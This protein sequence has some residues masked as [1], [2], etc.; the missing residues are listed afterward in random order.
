MTKKAYQT[1]IEELYRQFDTQING[2]NDESVKE[3]QETYGLNELT[4]S[5]GLSAGEILW[6]NVNNIIVYLLA[7]AIIISIFMG[8]YIEAIAVFVALLIAV[9]TGFFVELKA[10]SSVDALKNMIFT[11]MK[12]YR[13]GSLQEISSSEIVPGDIISLEEGD[14]IAA[15]ARLIKTS[16]FAVIEAALTGESEAVDK[17]AEQVFDEELAI[18][19]RTNMVFSGT[20]VARGNALA[21]VTETGMKTEVGQ[22]SA[23]IDNSQMSQSPLDIELKKLGKV[24]IVVAF[25]AAILVTI[26]GVLTGQDLIHV[27]HIALIL[28]IAAIPEALPAVSTITL[29]RGMKVMSEHKALVKSLSAVE[30]LGSTTVIA[31]DKTGTLTENQMTAEAVY[32][33]DEKV[34]EVSGNGYQPEGDFSLEGQNQY[35]NLADNLEAVEEQDSLARFVLNG[36]LA[37]NAQL[38]QAEEQSDDR[39]KTEYEII[40]DPTEGALVVLAA[41]AGLTADVVKDSS[42]DKVDEIPFSSEKK[43]MVV[44]YAGPAN[45]VIIKGAPDVLMNL[46]LKDGQ[47]YDYWKGQNDKIAEKGMRVLAVS[48]VDLPENFERNLSLEEL[49]K[50]HLDQ[51][52]FDGLVGIVD[53][54][55]EDVKDA[56][57]LTQSA[58]I[59]V[60]MITGD[61]PRTAS[62]IAQEIGIENADKIMTGLEIDQLHDQEGFAE[63]VKE[64]AVFARVS[65]ENK[66]QIVN[67]L[68]SQNE[69]VAMTGDGVNDAPALNGA[70]IGV[71][72]GIRGTEVAKESSDM[73]LTDDRFSTIVDAVEIGR[74]IFA[75]IKKYVAFLFSCN[76]VEILTVL[77]SVIFILPMPIQALHILFLNLVVDIGPALALAFESSEDD[78]MALP[79]RDSKGGLVSRQ[80]LSQII[81]SGIII[82]VSSFIIFRIAYVREASLEYAQTATFTFMALAQLFHVFNVRKEKGFGLDKSLLKNNLLIVALLISFFLQLSV[83]YVPVMNIIFGTQPLTAGTW[84]YILIGVIVTTALVFVMNNIMKRRFRK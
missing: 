61:H 74:I 30:T 43:Y 28:A 6:H 45:R 59:K 69:V 42:W 49:M 71:A 29:S 27:T 14:A 22:I 58:G 25:I 41:K 51:F 81:T 60:K 32:L 2:L 83:V 53:P 56:V 76:M 12:V 17:S 75:N 47:E 48:S 24:L 33:A 10:Q 1:T 80:F 38:R 77:L 65:P 20:A 37:S 23:L 11:T 15:D 50:V 44:R 64:T 57:S 36:F 8:E 13:N 67:S 21:L 3:K 82:A 31:S 5:E 52:V 18:G 73:I 63:K 40:G 66:L 16:N 39:V 78:I 72:M 34:V 62:I 9:L 84:F 54:P 7:G 46:F 4:Q 70:D 35:L 26:I 19:D 68:K 79:P 55:R